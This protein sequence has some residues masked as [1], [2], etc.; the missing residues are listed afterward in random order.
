MVK[1]TPK[2][3]VIVVPASAECPEPFAPTPFVDYLL[4]AAVAGGG[5]SYLHAELSSGAAT[6]WFVREE[7]ATAAGD[8]RVLAAV[9]GEGACRAALARVGHHYMGG[10]LYGGAS[11]LVL[12]IGGRRHMAAFYMAN[13]AWRGF[14]LRAYLRPIDAV[15]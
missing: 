3:R 9:P 7:P 2:L 14:W 4:N 13:D 6:R 8:E 11:E 15:D 1:P 10:Q 12:V 5:P